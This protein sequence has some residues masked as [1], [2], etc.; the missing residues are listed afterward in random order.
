MPFT[1]KRF[2]IVIHF[3]GLKN[4]IWKFMMYVGIYIFIWTVKKN[5]FWKWIRVVIL[6]FLDS[7]NSGIR[8]TYWLIYVCAG[9]VWGCRQEAVHRQRQRLDWLIDL[10]AGGA[11]GCRQEAVHRQRQRRGETKPEHCAE[12]LLWEQVLN[13]TTYVLP[14]LEKDTGICWSISALSRGNPKL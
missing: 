14:P 13:Q 4:Y 9:G 11:W 5:Y 2:W 7:I 10:F 6:S 12:R 8:M 3:V 1:L